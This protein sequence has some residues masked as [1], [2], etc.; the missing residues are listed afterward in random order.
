MPMPLT[1]WIIT[2]SLVLGSAAASAADL[3]KIDRTITKEPA[4]EATPQYCLLVFGPKAETRVWL[5]LDG[6]ILYVDRNS[7]GDLTDKDERVVRTER[8]EWGEGAW[9]D[10]YDAG[11][12]AVKE[13]GDTFRLNA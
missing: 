6:D 7:N 1:P 9:R 4:Y 8:V 3:S 5:V 10:E 2:A 13:S 12:I 11:T